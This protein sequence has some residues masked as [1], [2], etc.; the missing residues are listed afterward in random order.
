MR[1]EGQAEER[2]AKRVERRMRKQEYDV[3]DEEKEK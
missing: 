1:N 2:S 3:C